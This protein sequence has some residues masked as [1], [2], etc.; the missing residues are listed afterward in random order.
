MGPDAPL[1]GEITEAGKAA[2]NRPT[3]S[4]W[5]NDSKRFTAKDSSES[6]F[7]LIVKAAADKEQTAK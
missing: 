4:R 3:S 2:A 6:D 5:H 1:W 7:Q